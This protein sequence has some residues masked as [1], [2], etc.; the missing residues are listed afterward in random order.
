M[1][2]TGDSEPPFCMITI[3]PLSDETIPPDLKCTVFLVGVEVP[4]ELQLTRKVEY[5]CELNN[6]NDAQSLQVFDIYMYT[7][8]Y[9]IYNSAV[10]DSKSSK[11]QP[12]LR[13]IAERFLTR[14][15]YL[16]CTINHDN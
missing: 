16:Q 3:K 13:I 6:C 1:W 2:Y 7:I 9:G 5:S 4:N 15:F 11:D 10:S 14:Q 12:V 8:S